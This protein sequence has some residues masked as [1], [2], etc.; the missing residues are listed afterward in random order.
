MLYALLFGSLRFDI[1]LL[2]FTCRIVDA[3]DALHLKIVII[4]II[5]IISTTLL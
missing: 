5:I 2:K 3:S 1:S 4:I